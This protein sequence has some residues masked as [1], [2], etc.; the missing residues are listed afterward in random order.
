[1]GRDMIP[2]RAGL[3]GKQVSHLK[4]GRPTFLTTLMP[5]SNETLISIENKL[6]L[7]SYP[8]TCLL[9]LPLFRKRV[10]AS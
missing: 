10:V 7:N 2:N 9:L 3:S 5:L 8:K 4:L 6:L 1:M